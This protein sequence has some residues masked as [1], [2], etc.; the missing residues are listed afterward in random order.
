MVVVYFSAARIFNAENRSP[1]ESMHTE[2]LIFRTA[3]GAGRGW[4]GV[5]KMANKCSDTKARIL[6]LERI[7]MGAQKP[8]KCDEIID[9]LYKQYHISANRKTIYDD[10]AVLTAFENVQYKHRVGYWAEKGE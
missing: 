9:R 2:M 5:R 10:I 1:V 6:A 7:L 4:I 8:L 3:N